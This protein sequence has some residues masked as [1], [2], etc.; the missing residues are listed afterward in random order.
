VQ[1]EFETSG[2]GNKNNEFRNNALAASASHA[3]LPRFNRLRC[4]YRSFGHLSPFKDRRAA[5]WLWLCPV[6]TCRPIELELSEPSKEAESLL[7][8][9]LKNPGSFGFAIFWR[10]AT[11]DCER[12]RDF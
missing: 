1:F 9:I 5:H 7:A 6:I 11:V 4:L 12:S 10:D 8:S 2:L 3:E